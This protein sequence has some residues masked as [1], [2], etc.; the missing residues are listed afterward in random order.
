MVVDTVAPTTPTVTIP[1]QDMVLTV[2]APVFTGTAEAGSTVK[3]TIGSATYSATTSTA[4][5]YS[6]PVTQ[7]LT[8]GNY[9]ASVTATDAAGNISSALSRAFSIN[10]T[11]PDTTAPTKP[12][13]LTASNIAHNRITLSWSASIDS[14]GVVEYSIYRGTSLVGTSIGTSFIDTGLSPATAYSYTVKAKDASGNF[15]E[16][17]DALAVSTLAN[18][19]TLDND[20]DGINDAWETQYGYSSSDRTQPSTT[21]DTDGDAFSDYNEG[22]FGSNPNS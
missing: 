12:L 13:N 7:S 1:T 17:S 9:T 14:V 21:A 8:N 5:T 2:A 11:A 16:A 6:V 19:Q 3:V 4:G 15:S 18:I 22:L 10:V 20:C